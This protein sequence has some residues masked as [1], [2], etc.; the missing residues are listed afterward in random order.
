MKEKKS[1]RAVISIFIDI[2]K[3]HI[4]SIFCFTRVLK[5]SDKTYF[6][7]SYHLRN[8]TPLNESLLLKKKNIDNYSI[9][10]YEIDLFSPKGKKKKRDCRNVF[11]LGIQTGVKN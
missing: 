3:Y 6:N 4:L 9:E 11:N 10:Q 2:F 5:N 8:F 7:Y 1:L